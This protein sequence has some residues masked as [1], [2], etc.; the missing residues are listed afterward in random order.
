[1]WVMVFIGALILWEII[2]S[3]YFF[4][5]STFGLI[6]FVLALFNWL[7]VYGA[8]LKVHRRAFSHIDNI[9]KLVME[10]KYATVRHPMYLA[11]IILGLSIFI[12]EPTYQIMGI[13]VWL[14]LV[15]LFW[16]NM[17]ERLLEEKFIEDYHAYKKRVPMFIPKMKRA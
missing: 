3:G 9:N 16:A 5:P 11:D 7:Y 17:E 6:M 1:M 15:L 12:W 10:G 14:I 8:S 2:P 13:I 4:G